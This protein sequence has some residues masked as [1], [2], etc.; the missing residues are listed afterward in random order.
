MTKKIFRSICMASMIVF[1]TSL[2]L[3]MGALYGYF[4]DIQM[5]QLHIQADMAARGVEG[6]GIRY[7]EGLDEGDCRITWIDPEGSVLF[8]NRAGS[9]GMEN[10]L[11]RKEIADAIKQGTGESKRYSTTLLER[12]L[13]AAVRLGDGTVLRLSSSQQTWW[14]LA[15]EMLQPIGLVVLAAVGF[16]LFLAFRLS[17]WIIRPLNDLNLDEPERTAA[18]E[19]IMPL[20][21]RIGSQQDRLRRQAEEAQR[22][23][24]EFES[25]TKNMREGLL[26]LNEHG[27]VLSLND[28]ASRILGISRYCVGKDFLLFH[29]SNDIRGLLDAASRGKHTETIACLDGINYQINAS[30]VIFEDR[31]SGIVLLIFDISEKEKAEQ[32]RREF[33]ANV[34]H[35][36]KT[37][38]QSISGY[39]EL[40]CEGMVRSR[41][42]PHFCGQIL[43]ESRRMVT[44]VEDIIRLSYLDEG[45]G[46][47]PRE[48]VDLYELSALA[49]RNL[50]PAARDAQVAVRLEGDHVKIV[51]VPVLL[52]TILF[53]L[54]DNAVKYNRTGGSVTIRI[55]SCKKQDREYAQVSV[56]DTGIGIPDSDQERIFERFYRVDKS[57]SKAVGGTGLGLS[58]VKH[59]AR[60]HDAQ[61]QVESMVGEGTSFTVFF[62][63]KQ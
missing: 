12:Q 13:Y 37:P 16:S 15:L 9:S 62:P 54:C 47:M 45:A 31:V 5:R 20:L 22:R 42:V 53:N 25:A 14:S 63:M 33:T 57:R 49:I 61:I 24:N 2:V 41:D 3:I 10:H 38:L 39:A 7:L 40:L 34:S 43:N 59:A 23:K 48:A 4:T 18:Y 1:F 46:D 8:D 60:A 44:L 36:L 51:G 52:E 55:K 21:N 6:G 27:T 50:A 11:E 35:E 58:I 56:S 30:P 17:K 28:S 19:E 32:M 26:L 29:N